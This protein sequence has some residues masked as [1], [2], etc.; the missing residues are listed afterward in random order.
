MEGLTGLADGPTWYDVVPSGHL[1]LRSDKVSCT[2][3]SG[4]KDYTKHDAVTALVTHSW[5]IRLKITLAKNHAQHYTRLKQFF[6]LLRIF[7]GTT[8]Q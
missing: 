2:Y 5:P 3:G 1:K 8:K 7:Q 4:E 6:H